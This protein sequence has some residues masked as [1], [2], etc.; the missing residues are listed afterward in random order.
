MSLQICPNCGLNL[1]ADSIV[2]RDGFRLDPRGGVT[3]GDCEL[4]SRY[5]WTSILIALA[6]QNRVLSSR[7]L[8]GRASDSD[9][10]NTLA[11]QIAQMRKALRKA[12]VPDP[13][14]TIRGRG[15]R[16]RAA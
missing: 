11:S 15:Y 7:A 4:F 9:R 2:E 16:W 3:Y 8:L 13:I 14:E 12:K 1:T 5:G 6:S 10:T